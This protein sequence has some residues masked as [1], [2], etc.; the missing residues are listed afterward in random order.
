MVLVFLCRLV[1][2]LVGLFGKELLLWQF[3]MRLLPAQIVGQDLV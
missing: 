3:V 1:V 2:L